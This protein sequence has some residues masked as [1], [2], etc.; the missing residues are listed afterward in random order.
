MALIEKYESIKKICPCGCGNE[1]TCL[2]GK[3]IYDDSNLLFLAALMEHCKNKHIWFAFITGPWID[4][5]NRDC[6]ITIHTVRDEDKIGTNVE[7]PEESPWHKD[8]ILNDFRFLNKE[9]VG[10]QQ[11]GKEWAYRSFDALMANHEDISGF[12]LSGKEFV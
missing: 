5:D 3:L 12:L 8:E 2:K 11:G 1:Y 9:E 6:V 10:R 7:D 4:N